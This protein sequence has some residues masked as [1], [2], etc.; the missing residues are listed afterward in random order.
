MR[1]G[2]K[3]N[4]GEQIKCFQVHLRF[5]KLL[6]SGKHNFIHLRYIS[7]P[8]RGINVQTFKPVR[9]DGA[10]MEDLHQLEHFCNLHGCQRGAT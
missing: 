9:E 5:P 3:L 7:L 2:E 8:V 10:S 1:D 6:I 4:K